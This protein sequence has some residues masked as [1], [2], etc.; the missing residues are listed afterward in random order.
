MRATD[1]IVRRSPTSLNARH[2]SALSGLRTRAEP[3]RLL[4]GGLPRIRAGW[5]ALRGSTVARHH[6]VRA[7][8][9]DDRDPWGQIAL[10]RRGQAPRWVAVLTQGHGAFHA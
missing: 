2:A 1:W 7:L 6:T 10:E 8:A 4:P 5:N 9:L 3:A